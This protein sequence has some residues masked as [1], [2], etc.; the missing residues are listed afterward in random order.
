MASI[1]LRVSAL[2]KYA[3]LCWQKIA[4]GFDGRGRRKLSGGVT[5]GAR[6]HQILISI[7]DQGGPTPIKVFTKSMTQRQNFVVV[8][9]VICQP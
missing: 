8:V 9:R 3:W 4:T 7:D 2:I 1:P 5:S 6:V